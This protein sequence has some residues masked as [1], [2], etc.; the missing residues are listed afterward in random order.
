MGFKDD[1]PVATHTA[2]VGFPFYFDDDEGI[3]WGTITIPPA[4]VLPYDLMI[5]YGD[6][7]TTD[8]VG[9]WASRWDVTNYSITCE[10]WLRKSDI[11]SLI[12]NTRPGATGEL[13]QI[14]GKPTYYDKSWTGANTIKIKPHPSSNL[15]DMRSERIVYVKNVTT[16]PITNTDWIEIKIEANLSGSQDI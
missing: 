9:G 13:Y 12:S 7:G 15:S 10:T 2:S 8:F 14:L 11:Q 3:T 1:H 4:W 6:M 5:Y 16:H